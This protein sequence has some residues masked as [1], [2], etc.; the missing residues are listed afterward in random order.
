[1]TILKRLHTDI[2]R[3]PFK[4][5]FKVIRD[6]ICNVQAKLKH[7]NMKHGR[8]QYRRQEGTCQTELGQ[9][10][11]LA[12]WP[13]QPVLALQTVRLAGEHGQVVTAVHHSTDTMQ[14]H[15]HS[16]GPV[17]RHG[18]H[19]DMVESSPSSRSGRCS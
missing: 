10:A 15:Q 13:R 18:A 16:S 14:I 4:I 5:G 19:L 8:K 2:G 9:G 6:L 3:L 11:R 17:W 1:M 12:F 7:L